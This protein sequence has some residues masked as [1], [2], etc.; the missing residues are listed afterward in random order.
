[1][2]YPKYPA[3]KDSGVEW[4]EKIPEGWNVRKLKYVIK[5]FVGGG[6]PSTSY[7]DYWD[8]DIPWVSISDI[9]NSGLISNTGRMITLLGKKSKQLTLLNTGTIIYSMYASVGKVAQLLIPA[10]TN[11]AIV[12]LVN[13]EEIVLNEYLRFSLESF[14]PFVNILFSSNTQNNINEEKV[15]NITIPISGLE[16]QEKIVKFLKDRNVVIEITLKKLNK[17]IELLK[18]KRQAIITHAVTKGLDPNVPM[19]DSGVE[20]IGKIPE[21]WTS[22]KIKHTSYVK[23]RV[24]WKGLTS[25]EYMSEGYAYL[26]TGQDFRYQ[27]IDWSSCYCVDKSR[28]DDDPY[29]QLR[30]GDLL[31][32]KDGTIGK[33]AIVEN[34]EKPACLNSGIFLVRPINSYT[35]HFLSWVLRSKTFS[36]FYDLRSMG[37]TIQHLYQNVFDN[38]S[39]PIPPIEEQNGIVHYLNSQTIKIDSLISNLYEMIGLLKD[40]RTSLIS[41]A[42]TGK[43]DVR[44]LK[45]NEISESN[46]YHG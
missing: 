9:T 1:M 37:S 2:K 17:M 31:I 21:Y 30:N 26:V 41:A 8:G 20:W 34:L 3:Y 15:K 5:N 22:K 44:N 16:T 39:F 36:S 40:H 43:I 6:T 4:I 11:Q 19:K 42:M 28:Y 12:G 23:G 24:G 25:E 32:T 13:N 35:S 38:F 14:E 10:T 45:I 7:D 27:E 46:K 18:E 33:L 29:I